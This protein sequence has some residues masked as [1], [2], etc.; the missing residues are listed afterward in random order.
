[1]KQ[2]Q[3][4]KLISVCSGSKG[5]GTTWFASTLC[6]VLAKIH[7]KILFFDADGGNENIA[8]Q[9]DLKKSDLFMKLLKNNITLNNAVTP[10]FKGHFDLIYDF[11]K[12]NALMFYPT[13]RG[14]ILAS[15][16]KNFSL[17]YDEVIIDCSENNPKI[18]NILLNSSDRIIMLF[19][20]GLKSETE[21]YTELEH[22]YKIAP[23]SEVYIVVNRA[24]SYNEGEQ[25]Y[26][27]FCKASED[28]IGLKPKLLG[29]LL[30]DGNIRESILNK[31]LF[32]NRYP[33]S[34]NLKDIKKM[35]ELLTDGEKYAL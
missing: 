6:H 13:G 18:K 24:L 1:M 7:R 22:I 32:A 29:V 16:L 25:S 17:N 31:T 5:I 19:S 21:A 10:Y 27:T 35:A 33:D 9:L 4:N 20:P 14:Q 30:Q 2:K 15:D 8:Y 26:K 28:F 34:S 12:E 3:K 23:K 11:S